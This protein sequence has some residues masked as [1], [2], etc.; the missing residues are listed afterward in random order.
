MKAKMNL[1]HKEM[2]VLQENLSK[3]KENYSLQKITAKPSSQKSPYPRTT[4]QFG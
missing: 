4:H 3:M 2:T 1:H